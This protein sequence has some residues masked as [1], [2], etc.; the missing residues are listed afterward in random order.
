[1]KSL[2]LPV[3]E[4]E[5]QEFYSERIFFVTTFIFPHFDIFSYF[6]KTFIIV[7][8]SRENYIVFMPFSGFM[9]KRNVS[10][11]SDLKEKGKKA[12]VKEKIT[13]EHQP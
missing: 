9:K 13:N 2:K 8:K 5:Q 6:Y 1:M 3:A 11:C 10:T 7:E 12:E 4:M